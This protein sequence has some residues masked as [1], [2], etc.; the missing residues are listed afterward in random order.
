[1]MLRVMPLEKFGEIGMHTG[2][3]FHYSGIE[4]AIWN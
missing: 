3:P 1:M 2:I 4:C